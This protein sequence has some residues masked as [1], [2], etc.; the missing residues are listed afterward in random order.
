MIESRAMPHNIPAE[1]AILGALMQWPDKVLPAV[2]ELGLKPRHFYRPDYGN[3]FELFVGMEASGTPI[4]LA[5]TIPEALMAGGSDQYGDFSEALELPDRVSTPANVRHYAELVLDDFH[6]RQ[7]IVAANDIREGAY[8]RSAKPA[9][10]ADRGIAALSCRDINPI[11]G[12]LLRIGSE[13]RKIVEAAENPEAPRQDPPRP[14]GF[15]DLDDL[16]G[17]GLYGGEVLVLAGRPAMGKSAIAM[18]MAV[19][20]ARGKSHHDQRASAVFSLEMRR[21]LLEGRLLAT[22][23]QTSAQDARN[24]SPVSARDLDRMQWA[25]K[26]LESVPLFVDQTPGQ[27]M[28]QITAR[29]RRL[30]RAEGPLGVIVIDYL[31]LIKEEPGAGR[32][33]RE[34]AVAA[35][36]LNA[37]SWRRI[38]TVPSSSSRS[39]T[40]APRPATTAGHA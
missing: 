33:N 22:E 17:G 20:M 16:L 4:T 25:L 21:R 35:M 1:R 5:V 30:H 13:M 34:Q 26:R 10:L 6:H 11:N 18:Q 15:R 32:R 23:G 31:Q 8:D 38:S 12:G 3:L 9:E 29:A 40:G 2:A 27:T 28:S 14:T 19:N 7:M 39:S 24:G 37:S 36:S